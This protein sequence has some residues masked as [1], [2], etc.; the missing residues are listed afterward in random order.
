MDFG[1][2]FE[3]KLPETGRW[4]DRLG[5]AI[6]DFQMKSMNPLELSEQDKSRVLRDSE[7]L[8]RLNE[9]AGRFAFSDRPSLHPFRKRVIDIAR[10]EIG[11]VTDRVQGT[12]K[13]LDEY[14]QRFGT[15]HEFDPQR[16]YR[17]GM[18]RL[19]EYFTGTID[20]EPTW[21]FRGKYTNQRFNT[22]P[23]DDVVDELTQEEG[24][25]RWNKRPPLGSALTK[26]AG[27]KQGRGYY[28]GFHWCGVFAV[29][30]LQQAGMKNVKW[31]TKLRG[32]SPASKVAEYKGWHQAGSLVYTDVDYKA[33]DRI[34]FG[35]TPIR[36]GDIV[37]IHGGN[38]HHLIVTE[39]NITGTMGLQGNFKAIAGNSNYQEVAEES[40]ALS[41]IYRIYHIWP[42]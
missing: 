34:V 23:S 14:N 27:D 29:W 35:I 38:N 18:T 20:P 39:V 30:A 28:N 17:K 10:A 41:K 22:D 36:P 6:G 19:R 12:R 42:A 5:R 13:D 1:G 11:I 4:S 3:F 26:Y 8:R 40:H 9:L 15:K 32:I 16:S 33:I 24:I 2:T 37:I 21:S 31:S 7:T 25:M